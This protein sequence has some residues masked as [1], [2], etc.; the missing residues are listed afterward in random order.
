MLFSPEFYEASIIIHAVS[1]RD[2]IQR[3]RDA[4][5]KINLFAG[6]VSRTALAVV[7]TKLSDPP[8][9]RA[10]SSIHSTARLN[11]KRRGGL[12]SSLAP[13]GLPSFDPHRHVNNDA[14]RRESSSFVGGSRHLS[15]RGAFQKPSKVSSA[16]GTCNRIPLIENPGGYSR[17]PGLDCISRPKETSG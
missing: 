11:K 7:N 14:S 5:D 12:M 10:A 2:V 17:T 13:R 6:R 8:S 9:L 15:L 3:Y 16:R 1:E 4:D